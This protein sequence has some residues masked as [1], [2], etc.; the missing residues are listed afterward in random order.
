MIVMV[1]TNIV[2]EVNEEN[3]ELLKL[4]KEAHD[5]MDDANTEITD[6]DFVCMWCHSGSWNANGIIHGSD[7]I[8]IRM[9]IIEG[10]G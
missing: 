7:C 2:N 5:L 10:V 1:P 4:L 8:H 9:R 3:T 6:R